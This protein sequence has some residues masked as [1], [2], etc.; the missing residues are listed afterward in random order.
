MPY[1]STAKQLHTE[2]SKVKIHKP[3]WDEKAESWPGCHCRSRLRGACLL[4]SLS[5]FQPSYIDD[6]GEHGGQGCC[7]TCQSFCTPSVCPCALLI[8]GTQQT[9]IDWIDGTWQIYPEAIA[10]FWNIVFF[11]YELICFQFIHTN[12]SQLHK[13]ISYFKPDFFLMGV[14]QQCTA[15]SNLNDSHIQY[16]WQRNP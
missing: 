4:C 10:S 14:L 16:L 5:V 1:S 11:I 7:S 13:I 2:G 8:V 6:F 3:S 12:I 15:S 9:F